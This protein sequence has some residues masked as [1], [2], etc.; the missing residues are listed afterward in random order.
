VP[1]IWNTST[2]QDTTIHFNL[3]IEEDSEEPLEEFSRL[4]RLGNFKAAGEFF[5]ANLFGY[6]EDSP[7]VAVEY[8]DM[9][10]EQGDYERLFELNQDYGPFLGKVSSPAFQS[11]WAL[12]IACAGMQSR[13]GLREAVEVLESSQHSRLV[14]STEVIIFRDSAA[15]S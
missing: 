14:L 1:T 8:A 7:Y 11:H 10:L 12:I 2:R 4:K 3:D 15:E 9:L 6:I 5:Q 13:G